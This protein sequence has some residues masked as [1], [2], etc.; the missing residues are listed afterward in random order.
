MF[1]EIVHAKGT[2]KGRITGGLS[3]FGRSRL[4][5]MKLGMLILTP[6]NIISIINSQNQGGS[7]GKRRH[8]PFTI[9]KEFGA[10]SPL[11]LTAA[12][13][14]ELF[15]TIKLCFY[16]SSQHPLPSLI[17]ALTNAGVTGVHRVP[18]GEGSHSTHD[19]SEAEEIKFAFQ[20]ITV[21][22][23]DGGTTTKDH[24]TA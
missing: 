11:F 21:T 10:A 8:K 18:H 23:N 7:P 13:N 15:H 24:W 1:I 5:E 3:I 2:H 19:T 22:W 14:Q 4:H 16:P 17:I 6:R 12:C 20:M 9:T